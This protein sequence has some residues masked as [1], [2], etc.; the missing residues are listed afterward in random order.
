MISKMLSVAF[1]HT[2]MILQADLITDPSTNL[3]S[4]EDELDAV[5]LPFDL[6]D[7]R[8]GNA[9]AAEFRGTAAVYKTITAPNELTGSM[10]S[11]SCWNR[12]GNAI[13]A[14]I[15]KRSDSA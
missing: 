12:V 14:Q 4:L 5:A 3:K 13:Q 1:L 2:D 11:S 15:Q 7:Y 6:K 10:A 9:F 8:I